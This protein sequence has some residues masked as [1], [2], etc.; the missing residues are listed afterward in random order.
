M[1]VCQTEVA[2]LSEMLRRA[3]K[4]SE[5]DFR[6]VSLRNFSLCS[7]FQKNRRDVMPS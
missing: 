6:P 1:L 4:D 3:S 7:M 5:D 2:L